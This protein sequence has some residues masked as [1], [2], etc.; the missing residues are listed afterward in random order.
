MGVDLSYKNHQ[1]CQVFK[2][3]LGEAQA[4]GDEEAM[5]RYGAR[6]VFRGNPGQKTKGWKMVIQT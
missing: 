1:K 5:K 6:L 4:V 3:N 2:K